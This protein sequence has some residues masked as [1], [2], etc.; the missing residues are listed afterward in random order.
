MTVRERVSLTLEQALD[1]SS[2]TQ[3]LVDEIARSNSPAVRELWRN[4]RNTKIDVSEAEDLGEGDVVADGLA[5]TALAIAGGLRVGRSVRELIGLA[6]ETLR[7]GGTTAD[8][9][10]VLLDAIAQSKNADVAALASEIRAEEK[11]GR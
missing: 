2:G 4:L 8:A 10:L 5:R 7:G 1:S 11:H 3:K 6:V 9:R